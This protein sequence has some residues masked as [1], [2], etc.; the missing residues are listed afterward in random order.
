MI[1][2]KRILEKGKPTMVEGKKFGVTGPE[3]EKQK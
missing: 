2:I 1:N 3:I